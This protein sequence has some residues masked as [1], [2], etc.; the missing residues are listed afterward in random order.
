MQKIAV[1]DDFE[2]ANGGTVLSYW[3]ALTKARE[4]ARIGEGNTGK[5]ITWPKRSTTTR[6]T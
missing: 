2:P 6:P 4:L 5:L 1:A 3:D